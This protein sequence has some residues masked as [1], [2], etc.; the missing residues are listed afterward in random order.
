MPSAIVIYPARTQPNYIKIYPTK[1]DTVLVF[2][3]TIINQ[4]LEAASNIM[5]N[6]KRKSAYL[7]V[8]F[9]MASCADYVNSLRV[10]SDY[11]G[12]WDI[13]IQSPSCAID[14]RQTIDVGG[15]AFGTSISNLNVFI[16]GVIKKNSV[17]TI[18]SKEFDKNNKIYEEYEV[19]GVNIRFEN[20]KKGTG[21]WMSESCQGKLEL[22]R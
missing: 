9:L 13:T 5:C 12:D 4:C 8:F 16:S 11:D 18:Y 14:E 10:T 3:K 7:S 21:T 15:G 1:N 22:S 19:A 17:K 2:Y 20:L 6:N